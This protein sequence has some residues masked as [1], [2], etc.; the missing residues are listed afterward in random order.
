MVI[1]SY[2][3]DYWLD[4]GSEIKISGKY[5]RDFGFEPNSR[6]VIDIPLF[7]KNECFDNMLNSF[8][9]ANYKLI[10]FVKF[11]PLIVDQSSTK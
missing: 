9:K 3:D 2:V 7:R 4:D 11:T 10:F 5:L 6:V 8:S 1:L